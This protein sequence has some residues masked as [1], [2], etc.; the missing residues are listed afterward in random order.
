MKLRKNNL[1]FPYWEVQVIFGAEFKLTLANL[2]AI[3]SDAYFRCCL[4]A[5]RLRFVGLGSGVSLLVVVV[6][7]E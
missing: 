1:S 5:F 3:T 2:A 7:S 6:F 4:P